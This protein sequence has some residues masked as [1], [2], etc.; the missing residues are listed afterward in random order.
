MRPELPL[1]ISLVGGASRLLC[2]KAGRI[3]V[4]AVGGGD[5]CRD[6]SSFTGKFS[7]YIA[8]DTIVGA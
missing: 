4:Y 1:D 8:T 2:G 3:T 7:I 6:I 5:Q